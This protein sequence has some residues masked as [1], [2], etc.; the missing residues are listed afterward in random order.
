M[1]KV[2]FTIFTIVSLILFGSF[3][4]LP[5]YT[6]AQIVVS[7]TVSN[8]GLFTDEV[9]AFLDAIAKY[10]SE[11]DYLS[12]ESYNS[13]NYT[14]NDFD[15]NSSTNLKPKL[16]SNG[17]AP[18]DKAIKYGSGAW[19][20]GR[21]QYYSAQYSMGDINS[22]NKGLKLASIPFQIQDFKPTSQDHYPLGKY[23]LRANLQKRS[24]INLTSLLS[25]AA[26]LTEAIGVA[27]GE[28]ASMPVV[29]GY[30]HADVRQAK[31]K[32][33]DF[34][35]FYN[36]RIVAYQSSKNPSIDKILGPSN[37]TTPVNPNPVNPK[38]IIPSTPNTTGIAVFKSATDT[39]KCIDLNSSKLEEYNTIQLWNCNSTLA[40][41]WKLKNGQIQSKV[42]SIWCL[43]NLDLKIVINTCNEYTA[44]WIHTVKNELKPDYDTSI[45]ITLSNKL[46]KIGE[47]LILESCSNSSTQSWLK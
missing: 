9:R 25:S 13:G 41:G 24:N 1:Y 23:A 37:P 46:G 43:N 15:A 10:E 11:S 31:W 33:N 39:K 35:N 21:Y 38:P 34:L 8:G 42:N 40:Q 20:I 27:S 6:K 29:A 12:P 18:R 22:A 32:L 44:K 3:S 16:R 28:W 14:K 47:Q 5:L 2:Q 36:Q 17:I 45:C 30:K 4:L 19:N 7:G 26:N